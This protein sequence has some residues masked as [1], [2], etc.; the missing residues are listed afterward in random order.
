[1]VLVVVTGMLLALLCAATPLAVAR[2]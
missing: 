2:A 1:M